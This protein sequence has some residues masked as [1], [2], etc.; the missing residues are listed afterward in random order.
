MR[1]TTFERLSVAITLVLVAC[2][3]LGAC[4]GDDPA[5]VII[6]AGG[7]APDAEKPD[8]SVDAGS[9]DGSV[10]DTGTDTAVVDSGMSDGFVPQDASLARTRVV[11][12]TS[13]IYS[14]N[15]G[16]LAGA[17]AKCQARADASTGVAKGKVFKAWLR[18][19]PSRRALACSTE[20]DRTCCSA[21]VSS[22]RTGT[23]SS[24]APSARRSPSTR[25][26]TP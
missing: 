8:S 2:A 23:V 17:D 13:A 26:A 20:R 3:A 12:I 1:K 10:V 18:P 7:S 14:G 19:L 16:G 15:L 24:T 22:R 5:Q 25:T 9:M 11:F 6:V 4:V 21:A